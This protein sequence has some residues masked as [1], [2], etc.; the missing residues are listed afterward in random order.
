MRGAS[1]RGPVSPGLSASTYTQGA[2]AAEHADAHARPEAD[3]WATLRASLDIVAAVA[4]VVLAALLAFTLPPGS[5]PRLV[6]A[7][8]VAFFAPGYLVLEAAGLVRRP[9][10]PSPWVRAAM[11]VGLSPAVVAIAALATAVVPGGFKPAPI[12]AAVTF[13][14]LGLAAVAL[15]R[16][17]RAAQGGAPRP[18]W[19]TGAAR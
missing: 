7:G 16:R 4:A 9:L 12:M 1:Q 17:Q 5:W 3:A 14:S 13:L 6:L 2:M 15:T 11:A 19:W 10:P 8:A 18:A